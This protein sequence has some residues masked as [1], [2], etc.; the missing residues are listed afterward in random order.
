MSESEPKQPQRDP[1]WDRLLVERDE[2]RRSQYFS[3]WSAIAAR[4]VG[5]IAACQSDGVIYAS[6]I[7]RTLLQFS[8]AAVLGVPAVVLSAEKPLEG[9]ALYTFAIGIA[10]LFCAFALATLAAL[11]AH[12]NF[13]R[14]FDGI[15]ADANIA[16][17]DARLIL[18]SASESIENQKAG[19]AALAA[20]RDRLY[21]SPRRAE[22]WAHIFGWLAFTA[23]IAGVFFVGAALVSFAPV[24]AFLGL[25]P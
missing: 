20:E 21:R 14:A 22:I 5:T 3:E 8:A 24:F 16:R 15:R 7:L 18:N 6:M 13:S 9:A 12:L 19:R 1:A 10:C 11:F 2:A 4:E 17:H 25:A 23:I